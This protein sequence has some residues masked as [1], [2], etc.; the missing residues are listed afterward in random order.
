M[1]KKLLILILILLPLNVG[2]VD[3]DEYIYPSGYGAG[4]CN[5]DFYWSVNE[6]NWNDAADYWYAWG[7]NSTNDC[8][9]YI[10]LD[11]HKVGTSSILNSFVTIDNITFRFRGKEENAEGTAQPFFY[12][13]STKYYGTKIDL[14][15]SWTTYT[16]VFTQNPDTSAAWEWDELEGLQAG[17]ALYIPR[18]DWGKATYLTWFNIE[19]NYTLPTGDV[20]TIRVDGDTEQTELTIYPASP[21]THYDKVDEA[22]AADSKYVADVDDTSVHYDVFTM[23][24]SSGDDVID[25]FCVVGFIAAGWGGSISVN[26]KLNVMVQHNATTTGDLKDPGSMFDIAN[27]N[28]MQCFDD[29][30]DGD[31]WTWNDIDATNIGIGIQKLHSQANN[32]MLAEQVYGLALYHEAPPPGKSKAQIIIID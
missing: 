1:V 19:I 13:D 5:S 25:T 11:D 23:D 8:E 14:T 28:Y 24:A 21:T 30:P 10:T 27:H 6:R 2:A 26:S 3:A 22:G 7:A 31:A 16:E 18:T 9:S 4:D 29:D 12:I 15:T 17:M 20:E 32:W